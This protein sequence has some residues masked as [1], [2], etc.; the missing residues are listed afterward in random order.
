MSA[1]VELL[2]ERGTLSVNETA[3]L[4]GASPATI[5]RDF[6]SLADNELATRTFGGIVSD[7]VSY[8]LPVSHRIPADDP[9]HRIAEAA[10]AMISEGD[11]VGLNG[12]TT[13]AEV[14]RQI[15]ARS[16]RFSTPITLVTNAVNLATQL[17][18]R[19][20]VTI[21]VTGGVLRTHS[22]E[23]IGPLALQSLDAVRLDYAVIGAEGLSVDGGAMC[24]HHDEAAVGARLA[25][26]ARRVIL[27]AAAHKL[28][29]MSLAS[30]APLD[31]IDVVISDADPTHEVMVACGKL[32]CEIVTV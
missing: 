25:E 1:I 26:H 18:L 6:G 4:L 10:A 32:G 23:L 29:R 9:R 5:R 30:I 16:E 22:Y 21:I 7:Q 8:A 28:G 27:V 13:T 31:Q 2:A 17:A 19:S 20:N 24:H 14:G 12:G 3:E 11:T 15:G